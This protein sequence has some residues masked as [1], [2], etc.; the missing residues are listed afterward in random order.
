MATI[1]DRLVLAKIEVTKGTDPT[2]APASDAVRCRSVTVTEGQT[3]LDRAVVKQTM[4][5]LAHV[6]GKQTLQA[7]IVCELRGSGAA[8][9]APEWGPLMQACRTVETVTPATS[10]AYAPSTATENSVTIYVYKDGLLKLVGSVGTFTL[11]ADADGIPIITFTMQ[12]PYVAPTATAVPGGAAYDATQ[13]LVL[14]SSDT[15]SDGAAVK[16]STFTLDAGN[17]VQEHYTTGNHEFVV[18]N[19]APSLTFTKDSVNTA[20]EWTALVAGTDAVMQSVIGATAGNIATVD[21][22]VGRRQSVAYSER[23]ERDTLDVT[24]M[25]YESTS[26]DQWTITLT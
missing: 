7:E 13:P 23:A 1:Y 22:P 6:I 25:L 4:G 14:K 15:F 16:V 3:N 8:G 24:Y 26:D 5:N 20:A 9:T 10:V 21:A 17:D 2:P 11:S 12:A 19:R 18:A